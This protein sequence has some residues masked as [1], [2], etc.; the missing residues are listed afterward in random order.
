MALPNVHIQLGQ[1]NMGRV[2]PSVDGVVGL[3]LTGAAVAEKLELN[4][5][6]VLSS[7]RDLVTLGIEAETNPLLDKE[8]KAFYAVA[9][10]GAELHLIVTA[11]ATT[12][13]QM[14]APEATS[15]L[16]RLVEAAAGRIKVVGV[17]KLAPDVYEADTEQGVDKDAIQAMQAA[18]LSAE[19]FAGRIYPFRVLMA[20]PAW[21]GK[22][23][24]LFKP[25]EASC[26]RVA[27]VLASDD[28]GR[29]AAVAQVLGRIASIEPQ[30]SIG[31]V[32]LGQLTAQGWFTDGST[33]A[34]KAGLGDLLHDAGY[35]F[36]RSFPTRNGCYLNG[37]PMCAPVTNDYATLELG[38]IIDKATVIVYSTYIG[39]IQGNIRV[40]E[41][42]TIDPGVCKSYEAMIENAVANSLQGQIS[43]F[44]SYID[45]VQNILSTGNLAI[46]CQI[47]P[48]G[49]SSHINVE[50][51]L[52]N[53]ALA[54]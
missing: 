50:L 46:S 53:P 15:P 36:Y 51:S 28:K 31:Y 5:P 25:A 19:S 10:E 4:K 39:E 24:K 40:A 12:M 45:P 6:Y 20:A 18:H 43:G 22:T 37:A 48:L 2:T 32:S 9:G 30:Q 23:D 8:I 41:D 33:M 26:N 54:K 44:Q 13:A 35:I 7:T 3:V 52:S 42:G 34:E 16:T 1:G 38:R 49:V 27:M 21:T 29:S 14:C 17:N 47:T 11:A